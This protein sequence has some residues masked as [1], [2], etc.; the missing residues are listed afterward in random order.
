MART[1]TRPPCR[2]DSNLTSYPRVASFL[3]ARPPDAQQDEQILHA[4]VVAV[5]EVAE[6]ISLRLARPPVGEEGEEVGCA[7]V[8]V[9]I[10]RS[11]NPRPVKAGGVMVV[12]TQ[13]ESVSPTRLTSSSSMHS[14]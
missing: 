10:E 5:V 2:D 1:S 8:V 14:G 7:D 4:N 13:R 3:R 12:T 11:K 6:T 9:T